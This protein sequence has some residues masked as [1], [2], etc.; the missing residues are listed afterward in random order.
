MKHHAQDLLIISNLGGS[1][2]YIYS[3][4]IVLDVSTTEKAE[5]RV[6]TYSV[7]LVLAHSP[8]PPFLRGDKSGENHF[9]TEHP[10]SSSTRR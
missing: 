6:L 9:T 2:D 7:S 3:F 5:K 10:C 8:C 1:A 4:A